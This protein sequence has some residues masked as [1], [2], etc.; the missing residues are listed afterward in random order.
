MRAAYREAWQKRRE[1]AP[2]EPLEAQIVAVVEMHP[3]YQKALESAGVLERDYTPESGE[4]NPFLH[5]GMHL[6][7]HEQISTDRPEG[8]A[9]LYKKALKKVG[10][11]HEAEH[12]LMECLGQML[13]SAHRHGSEP[14]E[15]AYLDCIRRVAKGK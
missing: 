1:G 9:R 12:R 6:A 11:I 13:W 5:M 15:R 10:D 7:I 8:I 2:L 4:S 3:E 14:D